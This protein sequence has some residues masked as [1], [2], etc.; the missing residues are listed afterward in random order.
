[1]RTIVKSRTYQASFVTNEW[2]A[3]DA[4]NF[5]HAMPRRMQAEPLMNA[6]AMAAGVRPKF[7]D[8]P[9][10][11]NASQLPDPHVGAEG[12]LDLFGRP[13]RESVCE[14]ER[15][16]DFSLPQALNLINGKTISDAVADPKGRVA[17]NVLAGMTDSAMVEDLYLS[18]LT[19]LP[20]KA[21]SEQ[22]MK[23]L[24]GGPR[25][26]RAQD[27]LWALLNSKGFLYVY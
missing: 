27:L 8:V 4:T 13:S 21:E 25:A 16:T 5:S 12:F 6:V 2:N 18:T 24:A 19:R 14:C 1:M 17:R 10:D 26:T 22:A 23:Y 7:P 9:E 3:G 20:T 15:R 11:T